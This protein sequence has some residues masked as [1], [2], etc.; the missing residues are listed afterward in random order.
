L[1]GDIQNIEY[2]IFGGDKETAEI[3]KEVR[4]TRTFPEQMA[5]QA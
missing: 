5:V 3:V 2:E 1:Q 4:K